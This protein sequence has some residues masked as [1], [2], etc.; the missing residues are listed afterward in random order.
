MG[1]SERDFFTHPLAYVRAER[2]WTYQDLVDV[3]ARHVG[4]IAA[5]REKAWRWENW[6]VVPDEDS[7]NALATELGVPREHVRRLGWPAWLPAGDR[8]NIELPWT[9]DASRSMLDHTAGAAVLDRRGFLT[10]SSGTMVTI[11]NQWLGLEH[12]KVDS[13]LRGGR[14][15]TAL[16]ECL[17]RRLPTVRQMLDSL[18]GGN[19]RDLAD[20][21]LKLVTNLLSQATYGEKIGTRLFGVAAELGRIAGWASFDAG[22]HASAERYFLAGLRAA[23]SAGDRVSGANILKCMSLQLVDADRAEEALAVA[24]AARDGAKGASKRV[25]AMMTVREARANAV[26]GAASECEALLVRADQAMCASD[27]QSDPDWAGYFDHAE[28]SAQVAA[29]YML[30]KRYRL[31]DQWLGRSLALQPIERAVDLSTYLI[32]R[33]EAVLELGEVDQACALVGEAVPLIA[34]SR[35]TRNRRRL[36]GI[37]SK[38]AVHDHP[39]I[40]GLDEQVRSLIA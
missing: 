31:A 35:S 24:K 4:N 16:V 39:A 18:G 1:G 25:L 37:R 15:D 3:V 2:G 28:Y 17:E 40:V 14:V 20:A 5:R 36:A 38:L 6:G 19:V 22:Y 32:W 33:A 21:E 30:L 23:H 34:S 10:L 29:C 9:A 11:A 13:V 12:A 26:M 8:V 27:D 7:Q